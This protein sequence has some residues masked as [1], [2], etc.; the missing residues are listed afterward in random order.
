M[1]KEALTFMNRC[2]Y[3]GRLREECNSPKCAEK[4]ASDLKKRLKGRAHKK[5]DGNRKYK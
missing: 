3:C 5:R 4:A 2:N 1:S